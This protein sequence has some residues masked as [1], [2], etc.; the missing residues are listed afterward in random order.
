MKFL[1]K[2]KEIRSKEGE[3]YF[4]RFAIFECSF[5]AIYIHKIYNADK[6]PFCHNH[7][8]NFF[9]VI[10]KGGYIEK[11]IEK[12]INADFF[13][14]LD[15]KYETKKFL[16]L[17]WG[18]RAFFHKIDRMIAPTTTLFFTFGRKSRWGFHTLNGVVDFEEF[19]KN[20]SKYAS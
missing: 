2:V 17:G 5:F 18:S 8:W 13:K 7:P 4:T 19:I 20:K 9:S 11:Q 14:H 1:T 3:L 16:S 15:Y 12:W 6:D 10:L